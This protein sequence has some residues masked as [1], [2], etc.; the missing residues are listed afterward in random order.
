LIDLLQTFLGQKYGYRPLPHKIE[1]VEFEQLLAVIEVTEDVELVQDWYQEDD[2]TVPSDYVLQP[3]SSRLIHFRDHEHAQLRDAAADKW[4]E[5]Y[6]RL[7]NVLGKAADKVLSAEVARKYH[8][9]GKSNHVLSRVASRTPRSN[10][11]SRNF[12]RSKDKIYEVFRRTGL[13]CDLF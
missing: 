12:T 8:M 6:G 1:A 5:I 11:C 7:H 9:S 4:M 3:I 13:V 10:L 2:N